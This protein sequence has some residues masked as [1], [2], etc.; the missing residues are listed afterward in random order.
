MVRKR[1]EGG[2]KQRRK[3]RNI[4][5]NTNSTNNRNAIS[6]TTQIEIK[7]KRESGVPLMALSREYGISYAR[8]QTICNKMAEQLEAE[9]EKAKAREV[10]RK[11]NTAKLLSALQRLKDDDV[12]TA[13]TTEL[14]G[15][16][17]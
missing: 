9:A 13:S 4:M 1:K 5:S 3:E 7:L 12:L 6:I 10:E 11:A 16:E 15:E 8:V 2:V 14:E 17:V